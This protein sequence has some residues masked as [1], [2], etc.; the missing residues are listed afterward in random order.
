MS[1]AISYYIVDDHAL[2]LE[3]M[4]KFLQTQMPSWVCVGEA[5][6]IEE[7]RLSIERERPS[8]VLVDHQIGSSTG[9]E[10][11][12]SLSA[13]Y[14]A[15]LFI[16]VSQLE[17]KSLLND[18]LQLGVRAVISK[19]DPPDSIVSAMSPSSGLNDSAYISP[20]FRSLLSLPAPPDVLTPRE[21]DVIKLIAVGKTNKEVGGELDCSEFTVKTHKTNIMRKLNLNTSVE[22]SVWALKNNLLE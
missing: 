16:L 22:L 20:S 8:F 2:L 7:A 17:R 3:G 1:A 18:Y 12:K 15:S 4:K 13:V 19:K 14:P 6:D 5:F 21:L 9:L 11:I 10:L